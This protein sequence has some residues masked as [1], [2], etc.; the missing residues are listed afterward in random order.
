MSS[1]ACAVASYSLNAL[2]E[3]PLIAAGGWASSGLL[4]RV[5]VRAQ[6]RVWVAVLLLSVAAPALPLFHGV[7]PLM[8][9]PAGRGTAAGIVLAGG[10]GGGA[11]K[12]GGFVLPLWLIWSIFGA[13][14]GVLVYF[15][16]RL[17]WLFA[18][19][20]TLVRSSVHEALSADA[21]ALWAQVRRSF[22]VKHVEILHAAGLR[23]VVT[24]GAMRP[25][26]LLPSDFLEQSAEDDFLSAMGH[27]L[28]H[29]ERHDYAKNLFYEATSLLAAF[30]P[31]IWM[32]KRQIVQSREMI[33][34]AMVAERL[35]SRRAYRRSLLRLAAR[36]M[37]TYSVD[38]PAVGI[39]DA[40][41]LEKRIMAM[42]TKRSVP[43]RMLR[44]GL[45]GCAALLLVGLLAAGSA[46]A[47]RV[48]E[49]AKDHAATVGKVYDVGHGVK[50]PFAIFTPE[51]KFSREARRKKYQGTVNLQVV[52]TPEGRV[53]D[54][55]LLNH[56][57]MGLD[58]QAIKSVKRYRFKP[59]T[60][61][62]HPVAVRMVVEVAFHLFK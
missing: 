40:N 51:P 21:E 59:A 48:Q 37:S 54:I 46:L 1:L 17:L 47:K 20:R 9:A 18:G 31:V 11:V 42:K 62:G 44:A 16:G 57:K 50:P 56:L 38:I 28:A 39:F 30:H 33:C 58:E 12:T 13:Y 49:P 41:I 8:F 55:H 24:I 19:A 61:H 7:L 35:V 10:I 5:G 29:I 27:E 6:H 60:L 3:I 25:V 53:A 23:G 14:L 32:V 36:M 52:I 45:A 4:R 26:I 2:W 22:A 34:D 43:G 15:A